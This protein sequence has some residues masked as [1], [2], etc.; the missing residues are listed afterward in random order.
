M[1]SSSLLLLL[2][3]LLP[4]PLPLPLPL[5]FLAS[6]NAPLTTSTAVMAAVLAT[7]ALRAM[8]TD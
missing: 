4:L 2:L 8:V 1:W 5:L 3:L 6:P 7:N